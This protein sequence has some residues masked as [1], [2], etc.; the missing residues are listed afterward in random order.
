M[1]THPTTPSTS[2]A[3][4][5]CC[6]KKVVSAAVGAACTRMPPVMPQGRLTPRQSSSV[7]S[8]KIAPCAGVSQP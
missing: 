3:P 5:A 8:R 1:S 6:S 7:T 2:S 4:R